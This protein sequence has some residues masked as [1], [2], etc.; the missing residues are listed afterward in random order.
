MVLVQLSD[1]PQHLAWGPG[2]GHQRG[3]CGTLSFC[4]R[5]PN[6]DRDAC[7]LGQQVAW[8]VLYPCS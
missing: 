7:L 1:P 8:E 5:P 2:I 4:S 6:G 3:G